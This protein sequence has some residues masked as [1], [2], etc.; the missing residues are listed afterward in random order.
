M[1]TNQRSDVVFDCL[2]SG[3][4]R[5]K[6]RKAVYAFN[7]SLMEGVMLNYPARH[8]AGGFDRLRI[9]T[10]R[11]MHQ[12]LRKHIEEIIPLTQA[13]FAFVVS[14]FR[15]KKFKKHQFLIQAGEPVR[16]V[17]FIVSGLVKLA[18]TDDSGKQHIVSF[19]MEE[20]WESD[21]RA[22]YTQSAATLSLDCI[23]D[24]TAFCLSLE[25]YHRLRNGF[26]RIESFLL[27]KSM[28]G[29]IALQQR[30]LSL[31]STSA[32]ERYEQLLDQHA[33]LI[34]RVPKTLLAG[35]LGVSRETLSRL[36]S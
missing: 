28:L 25:D 19:A 26:P 20:W 5:E 35:Y 34:Q 15:E 33:S 7:G 18:Y 36:S 8:S 21:F 27:Q 9:H 24:T 31:L 4:L 13:E 32:K 1:P 17:Y 23:E 11:A 22:Y 10:H 3:T 14:H 16:Y 6:E 29:S 30:I 2:C 12:T